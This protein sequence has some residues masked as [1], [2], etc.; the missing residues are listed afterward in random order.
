MWKKPRKEILRD[1]VS[2]YR[3]GERAEGETWRYAEAAVTGSQSLHRSH[4][5]VFLT[6]WQP[7]SLLQH[8]QADVP[9]LPLMNIQTRPELWKMTGRMKLERCCFRSV[10]QPVS[11]SSKTKTSIQKFPHRQFPNPMIKLAESRCLQSFEVNL[12]EK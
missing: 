1:A 5:T 7:H 10:R 12:D 3:R 11:T 4:S 6:T 2:L 8:T 9:T